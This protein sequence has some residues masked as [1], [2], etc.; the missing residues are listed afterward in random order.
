MIQALNRVMIKGAEIPTAV[1]K[2]G[3]RDAKEL[4]AVIP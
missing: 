3:L 2:P 1:A 4:L